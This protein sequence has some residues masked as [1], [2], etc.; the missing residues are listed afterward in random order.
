MDTP[1]IDRKGSSLV[2]EVH[3]CIH[4]TNRWPHTALAF[5][6]AVASRDPPKFMA[7]QDRLASWAAM[8]IGAFSVS[9]RSMIW[10]CPSLR[11]GNASSELLLL[12]H[13][14][15]RPGQEMDSFAVVTSH[16]TNSPN[17]LLG[18]YTWWV[19][20]PPNGVY[21]QNNNNNHFLKCKTKDTENTGMH[22]VQRGLSS[23]PNCV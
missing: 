3:Y 15:Q 18:R 20:R 17:R 2:S 19:N 4:K 13:M 8:S 16:S 9:A 6:E 1:H 11:P 7:M 21:L 5:S 12:G 14:T 10:T 22:E 23:W